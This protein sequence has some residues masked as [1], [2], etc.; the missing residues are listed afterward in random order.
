MNDRITILVLGGILIVIGVL[1]YI[2]YQRT[3]EKN[4]AESTKLG[5]ISVLI[6]CMG[7]IIVILNLIYWP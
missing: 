3:I 1:L 6:C 7:I 2:Y 4:K 5:G